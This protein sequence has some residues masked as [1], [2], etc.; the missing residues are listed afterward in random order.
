MNISVNNKVIVISGGTSGVGKK[1]VYELSKEGAKVV[2]AGRNES[3]AQSILA[4]VNSYPGE[5]LF[6]KTDVA[7]ADD[8]RKMF[9]EAL[10]HYG[11]I[12]GFI[13]YAGITPISPLDSCSV[14][15]LDSVMTINFRAA[16][17]CCQEAVKAMRKS[18]GGSIVLIGS[19]HAWAGE[20]DRAAYACSKGALLTL[21]SHIAHNYA[22]E[23]IRCNYLTMGWTLTEGEISLRQ[24]IVDNTDKYFQDVAKS[25]PM[26]RMCMA[27]DYVEQIIYLLSDASKM[28][29]GSA[30]QMTGGL[31]I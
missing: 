21:M 14:E 6:V 10:S 22:E 11:R 25:L 5:A 12:D 28:L 8:C 9:S 17:L 3:M 31:F 29:T 30:I 20:K 26:K 1:M 18:G 2:F 13:N 24:S 27:D 7:A 19:L 23:N 16:F 15:T 4:D